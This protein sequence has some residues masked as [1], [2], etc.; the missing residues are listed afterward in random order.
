MIIYRAVLPNVMDCVGFC[1]GLLL[2]FVV[3]FDFVVN[4]RFS[5][6]FFSPSSLS[7]PPPY[8]SSCG[9]SAACSPQDQRTTNTTAWR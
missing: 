8:C 1:L 2:V 4:L 3:G 9:M 7:P 5:F 6:L